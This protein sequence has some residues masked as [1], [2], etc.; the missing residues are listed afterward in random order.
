VLMLIP[1]GSFVM[2]ARRPDAKHPEGSPNVDPS[3]GAIDSFVHEVALAA[4]FLSK[5]EMTQG[6]WER[7]WGETRAT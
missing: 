5:Y 3:A 7:L 6:Q 2:G 1:A 4:F